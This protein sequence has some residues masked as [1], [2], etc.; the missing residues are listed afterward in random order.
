MHFRSVKSKLQTG[1]GILLSG[2]TAGGKSA[3]L[4]LLT[5]KF[6]LTYWEKRGRKKRENW[7]EKKR[8]KIE[9]GKVENWKW[10]EEK[11]KNK[12]GIR[13]GLFSFQNHW[14][15]VWVYQNGNFLPGKTISR[16]EKIQEKLLAPSW[17]IFL[18]RPWLLLVRVMRVMIS[19]I[20]WQF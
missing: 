8:R 7:K 9:K 5:G 19:K 13:G 1:P 14:N 15:L 6:L 18:L 2:V 16:R 11:F 10:K 20:Y 4:T 12:E 3:P 17:K